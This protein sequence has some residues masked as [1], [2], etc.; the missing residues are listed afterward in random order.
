MATLD[1][2]MELRRSG[3][4]EPIL[5]LSVV[6]PIYLSLVID[7]DLSITVATKEWLIEAQE[8]LRDL[9]EATTPIKDSH[10][11]TEIQV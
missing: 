4:T 6:F 8:V 2:A 11:K 3:I 7:Y 10:I 9:E 1:E 5:V